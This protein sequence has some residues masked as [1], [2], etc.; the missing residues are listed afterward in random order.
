M[1]ESKVEYKIVYENDSHFKFS[2]SIDD[3]SWT[4]IVAVEENA[5]IAAIWD[6][7]AGICNTQFKRKVAEIG[8]TMKG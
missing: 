8:D 7:I 5:H 4:E 1:A 3:G 6:H 2:Q